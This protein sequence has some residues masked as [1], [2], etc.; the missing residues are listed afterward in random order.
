[1]NE[2]HNKKGSPETEFGAQPGVTGVP[3]L[4]WCYNLNTGTAE[5][6]RDQAEDKHCTSTPFYT[7]H[8]CLISKQ[9]RRQKGVKE[10]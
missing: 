5:I 8:A 9:E 2:E 7:N 10:Q 4:T 6:L 1:M 3:E